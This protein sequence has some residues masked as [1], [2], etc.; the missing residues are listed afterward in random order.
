MEKPKGEDLRSAVEL[1]LQFEKD[2]YEFYVD[3]SKRAASKLASDMFKFFADDEAVHIKR[4]KE[5]VRGKYKAGAPRRE[6]PQKRFK[7]V[8]SELKDDFKQSLSEA[9][10]ISALKAAMEIEK[11]GHAFYEKAA[12]DAAGEDEKDLFNFLKDEEAQHYQILKNTYDYLND[13]A[14]WFFADE[15]P[16]LDGG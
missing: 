13:V 15:G 16:M 12:D 5:Y 10:E 1:A 9:D 11:D 14:D 3:R 2:G 4:I 7:T 8:F 6:E